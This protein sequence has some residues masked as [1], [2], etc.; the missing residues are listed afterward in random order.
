MGL[1]FIQ[2]T[3]DYDEKYPLRFTDL[4]GTPGYSGTGDSA[5][6]Q[7]IQPYIKSIQIL[8]CPSDS[9]AASGAGLVY[10]YTDYWYNMNLDGKSQAQIGQVSNT[11]LNGDGSGANSRPIYGFNG[12]QIYN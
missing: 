8:Q 2:Y 6:S 5:W 11:I 9:T 10:G 4:D 12:L 1:S 7:T 3:Q